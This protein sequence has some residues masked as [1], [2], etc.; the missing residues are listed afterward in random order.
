MMKTLNSS[1]TFLNT[2]K[3]FAGIIMII[4]N[5]S[6]RFVNFDIGKPSESMI[7]EN[8]SKQL[9]IFSVAWMGTRDI[10][11][12]LTLTIAFTLIFDFLLNEKSSCCVIP[13]KYKVIAK[14]LDTDGDGVVSEDEINA[15]LQILEKAHRNTSKQNQKRALANFYAYESTTDAVQ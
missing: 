4:L 10:Y 13:E 8:I 1:V 12:A 9:L 7:R 2:N 6:S 11:I 3:I 15:A 14:A 5:I